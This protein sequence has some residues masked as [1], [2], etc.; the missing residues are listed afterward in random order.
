MNV[1]PVTA[2]EITAVYDDGWAGGM[3]TYRRGDTVVPVSDAALRAY[4]PSLRGEIMS[5]TIVELYAGVD[6]P[7]AVEWADDAG[8]LPWVVCVPVRLVRPVA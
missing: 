8:P 2:E 1:T 3:V 6:V 7:L 4:D 5:G